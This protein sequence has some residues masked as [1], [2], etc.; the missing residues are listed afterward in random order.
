VAVCGCAAWWAPLG[1][2]GRWRVG[3][4]GRRRRAAACGGMV[5]MAVW[6]WHSGR[7]GAGER[8][9]MERPWRGCV[10]TGQDTRISMLACPLALRLGSRHAVGVTVATRGVG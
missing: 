7:N 10:A 4:G 9:R 6:V 1:G 5:R 8:V 2:G 3:R